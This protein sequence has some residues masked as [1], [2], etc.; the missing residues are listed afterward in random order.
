[1][2]LID[3][4]VVDRLSVDAV[5]EL[6][7]TVN[8]QG[9]A[10]FVFDRY[11]ADNFKFVAIDAP[12]DKVVIGHYTKKSGW[13][14]DAAFAKPIDAGVDYT[15]GVSLKG[16]TVSVTLNGQAVVGF[17]YNAVTV[18]GYFGLMASTGQASFDDVKVKT[19]DRAFAAA[20][21]GAMLAA[22]TVVMTDNASTLTQAE[23]DSAAVT[24]MSQWTQALGN[25]D[26][27]L[28]GFGD[29]RITVANLGGD[30]LGY[31]QG[32]DVRIDGGAAGYG[33]A[34]HGGSMD[35]VTVVEHELGHVLGFDH[36]D[37]DRYPVM[38]ED[39]Q[40]GLQYLLQAANIDQHPDA[41]VSDATL[42]KLAKKAVELNFDLGALGGGASEARVDWQPSLG[43][44]A[45][46]TGYSPFAADKEA[47][48]ANFTDYLIKSAAG[49]QAADGSAYDALGQSVLG[50]RAA[51]KDSAP[52]ADPA[53]RKS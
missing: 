48:L 29:V 44:G 42:M 47:R 1:M 53:R 33:W 39:L 16:S 17:A 46:S 30:E 49:Q 11:S 40:P 31:T 13:V 25:G 27:R 20:G 6:T 10:G 4:P 51:G 35:L 41:P 19:S 43:E 22:D 3:L 38:H 36:G 26:P 18:D 9:R 7:T 45:W 52:S 21:G 23:L 50:K 34:S 8:T 15:L 12:A 2:S 32:R 14:E 28:A 37:A 24:A 5:L